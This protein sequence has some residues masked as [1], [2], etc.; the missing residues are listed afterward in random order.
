MASTH[1][2]SSHKTSQIMATRQGSSTRIAA[3]ALSLLGLLALGGCSH[4]ADSAGAAVD[5]NDPMAR[6]QA[7]QSIPGIPPQAKQQMMQS[8]Q[9]QAAAQP[10]P[11]PQ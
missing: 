9:A 6:A 4:G 10:A 5:T 2:H 7:V 3:T 11:K 8:A 1:Y